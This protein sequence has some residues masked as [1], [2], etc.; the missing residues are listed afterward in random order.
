M[1]LEMK[2]GGRFYEHLREID[3]SAFGRRALL[4]AQMAK[5]EGASE[6]LKSQDRMEWVARMNGIR[7]RADEIVLHV[8]VYA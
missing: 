4:I 8:L 5:R 6:E 2:N 1:Y 7:R 3:S